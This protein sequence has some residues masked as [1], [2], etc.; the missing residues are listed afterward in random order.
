MRDR[1]RWRTR[2]TRF[3]EWLEIFMEPRG[4][5]VD[6]SLR[7]R[8]LTQQKLLASNLDEILG[9]LSQAVT[10]RYCQVGGTET[11]RSSHSLRNSTASEM[12]DFVLRYLG[13]TQMVNF[14]LQTGS[15]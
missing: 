14:R 12:Y 7:R 5:S 11:G 3:I 6:R 2:A 1:R 13:L 4:D 10:M 8:T 9:L 15:R